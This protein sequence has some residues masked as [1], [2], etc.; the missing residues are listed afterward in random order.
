[1]LYSTTLFVDEK[2]NKILH[3]KRL[4][5][6]GK[7]KLYKLPLLCIYFPE[8]GERPEYTLLENLRYDYFKRHL[9]RAV[10]FAENE[11]GAQTIV[12]FLIE[13]VYQTDPAL[14]YRNFFEKNYDFTNHFSEVKTFVEIKKE[15]GKEDDTDDSDDKNNEEH[16]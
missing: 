11:A 6:I 8:K 13:Q 10:G 9:P 12:K 5:K 16:K 15:S 2:S 7:K 14:H 3:K 1:M 4:F